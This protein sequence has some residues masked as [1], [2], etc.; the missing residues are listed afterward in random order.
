MVSCELCGL[1]LMRTQNGPLRVQ[2][3]AAIEVE[4]LHKLYGDF[5]AVRG[6]SF[7]VAE[8]EVFAL[9]GPNGAGKSTTLEI[10]EGHLRRTA[11]RVSVLGADPEGGGRALRERIGIVLQSAGIDTELSVREVL[12]M[13]ASFYPAPLPVRDAIE[14]VGLDEKART[15][16]GALSGGQ[17]RRLDLALALIGN[18]DLIFLDEPTTGFDPAARRSAWQ[19]VQNLRSLGRTILL[20]SHYMDEVQ[21]LADRTAVIAAGRIVATGSPASLTDS[22]RVTTEILFRLP[23]PVTLEQIPAG[24]RDLVT[25]VDGRLGICTTEPTAMLSRLCGWASGAGVELQALEVLRPSL[26]DV[27]LELT[28]AQ[29]ADDV[30][31]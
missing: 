30:P 1:N 11:G 13:Y 19:L 10:L 8:G 28:Q 12:S 24:L 23:E 9:L 29:Q 6:I 18:P 7:R 22:K 5:E 15:R 31:A 20:T 25:P 14:I 21:Q 2:L 26:E 17:R 27:Y 16:I 3:M 4:D